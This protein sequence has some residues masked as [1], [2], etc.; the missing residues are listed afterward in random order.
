MAKRNIIH[1]ALAIHLDD[2]FSKADNMAWENTNFNPVGKTEW[3]EE[4]FM[5][6]DTREASIGIGGTQEDFGIYQINI[7]VPINTGTIQADNYVN[8]LS[9]LYKIGTILEKDGEQV[10][11][12]GSTASQG[13]MED[14]W[15]FIPFRVKWSCYMAKI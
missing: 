9:H 13:L 10:Y 2:N 8:E 1:R 11:I 3:F 6:N 5:P 4:Y 7:R 15:Y 12:E 14:N